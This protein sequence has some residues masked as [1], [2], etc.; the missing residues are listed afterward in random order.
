VLDTAYKHITTTNQSELDAIT[1]LGGDDYPAFPPQ[2]C[3]IHNALQHS[4]GNATDPWCSGWMTELLVD[5]LLQWREQSGDNRVDE[6]FIRL[7]RFMRDVG[8]AYFYGNP[9]YGTFLAPTQCF[10]PQN[11]E[12]PR[13]ITPAYGAGK[14][15]DGQIGNFSDWDD[16][17]H[18]ADTTALTASAALALKRQG[19]YDQGGPLGP[20]ATE[21]EAAAA[22]HEEFAFCARL[23]F[24]QESRPLR[25]PRVWKSSDLEPGYQDGDIAKQQAWLVDPA[26]RRIGYPKNQISPQRK[27]SWWFNMSLLQFGLLESA[28]IQ[29]PSITAGHVNPANCP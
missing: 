1:M 4:E 12:D 2:N 26:K 29:V 25:D 23:I 22:L 8:T 10:D 19:T 3:F 21:G 9:F 16:F 27:L 11:T 5:S 14:Y 20:F 15:M 17:E 7:S 18:C 24:T 13:M 28:G 6:I